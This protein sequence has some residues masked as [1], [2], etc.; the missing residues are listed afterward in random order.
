MLGIGGR[1]GLIA[2]IVKNVVIVV[3]IFVAIFDFDLMVDD[4]ISL[5]RC[6]R[7]ARAGPGGVHEQPFPQI[8]DHLPGD[9]GRV[10]IGKQTLR[11]VGAK[12]T[13]AAN[14]EDARHSSHR[15]DDP[16]GRPMRIEELPDG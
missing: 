3:A 6:V 4:A 12:V 13:E 16:G 15:T 7:Q 8:L 10:S 9:L 11:L 5:A 1:V 14:P 2:E